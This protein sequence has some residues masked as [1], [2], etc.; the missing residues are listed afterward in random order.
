MN[1]AFSVKI[2]SNDSLVARPYPQR[3]RWYPCP[4]RHPTQLTHEVSP[5]IHPR[6]W[7]ADIPQFRHLMSAAPLLTSMYIHLHL[8]AL[9]LSLPR[10]HSRPLS[11]AFFGAR[12]AVGSFHYP[13]TL[14]ETIRLV[15]TP[16]LQC[17]PN[18]PRSHEHCQS[19]LARVL[20]AQTQRPPDYPGRF[21]AE[22]SSAP[23][24]LVLQTP[25]P[26]ARGHAPAAARHPLPHTTPRRPQGSSRVIPT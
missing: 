10:S 14:M 3:N 2:S 4:G 21:P 1:T 24:P 7:H 8:L 26:R 15:S 9:P 12:Q 6:G 17:P 19:R 20:S 13:R 25:G 22:R 23:I 16:L 11:P 18:M 5:P